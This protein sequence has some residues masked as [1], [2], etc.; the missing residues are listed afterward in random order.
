MLRDSE[1]SDQVGPV[2]I[3]VE[4]GRDERHSKGMKDEIRKILGAL[5]AFDKSTIIPM[6]C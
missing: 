4:C 2:R 3:C 6:V 5:L 1:R